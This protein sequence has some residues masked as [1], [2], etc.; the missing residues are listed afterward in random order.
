MSLLSPLL[1]DSPLRAGSF[2]VTLYGDVVE[3]R[4]GRLWIGNL[5]ETCGAVGLS[6]SL[7]RTAVSRLVAADQL[8]GERDG[9]HSFYR[10]TETASRQFGLAERTLFEPA[11]PDSWRIL[12][13]P[14]PDDPANESLSRHG[15][16]RLAPGWWIG[17]AGNQPLPPDA[18]VFDATSSITP[19]LA[20]MAAAHWDLSAHASAYDAFIDRF[21]PLASGLQGSGPG[22]PEEA[23]LVR[24][25]LV[26]HFRHVALKDP[27]LPEAALP[28]D[29]SGRKA[30]RMF[31]SL[32][33]ALSPQANLHVAG[34]FVSEQGNLPETT[35]AI[36]HRHRVLAVTG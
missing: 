9:R 36:A 6:E 24:L 31:A 15:F 5:I 23:L 33:L 18:L 26:H 34:R 14:Q 28:S 29:W 2:I 3:P 30:R 22:S 8:A 12:W 1:A 21:Q 20:Q 11:T 16:A 32:Y 4:G 27:H 35:D 10:L 19:A 7:V 13:H 17:P 25:L